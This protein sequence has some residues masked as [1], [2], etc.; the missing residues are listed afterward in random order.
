MKCKMTAK[1]RVNPTEDLDKVITA[2]SN[3]FKFDELEIG[4]GYVVVTGENDS[5][6]PLRDSLKER[7]IRD[8]A[9]RMFI[10]G[11]EKGKITFSLSKQAAFVSIPNIVD[12]EMSALGEIDVTIETDNETVF[13]E[14]MT[15]K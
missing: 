15:Q 9:E 2:I 6:I 14:W 1:A 10:K 13:M 5:L 8:T 4:D 12:R 7:K 3:I 11:A